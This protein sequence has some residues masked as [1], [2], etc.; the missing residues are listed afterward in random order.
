MVPGTGS[1]VF[2]SMPA[3]VKLTVETNEFEV[4]VTEIEVLHQTEVTLFIM[5]A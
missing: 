5:N 1:A 3:T 2:D 4:P